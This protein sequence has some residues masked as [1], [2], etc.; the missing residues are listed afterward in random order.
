[1]VR[2][3]T[4]MELM[5]LCIFFLFILTGWGTL[6]QADHGLYAAQKRFFT[7]W[8][9]LAGGFF[10]FPGARFV[11]WVLSL[12]L[13]STAIFRLVYHWRK[14]GLILVH[15]GLMV[16]MMSAFMTFHF[17]QESFLALEEGETA[18][19]SSDYYDWELSLWTQENRNQ[20]NVTAINLT[21]SILKKA[22]LIPKFNVT[23]NFIQLYPN[24][25]PLKNTMDPNLPVPENVSGIKGLQS[26]GKNPD[27]ERNLPGGIVEFISKGKKQRV[28]FF[29]G[30]GKPTQI[31]GPNGLFLAQFRKV[32]KPLPM[33]V[34]LI[35]FVKN[36]HPGTEIASNYEST[37]E[38][39]TG[40]IKRNVRIYMNHP[41]RYKNFTF[42]QSSF[43][44]GPDG[45]EISIFSVVQN[46]GRLLPYYSCGIVFGGLLIHFLIGFFGFL[47]KQANLKTG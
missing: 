12:A 19:V 31:Q 10:P 11:L 23:L 43:S 7:S 13:L 46:K 42:F 3:L 24:A 44:V 26:I 8:Y 17:A 25:A 28:L 2:I 22:F 30:D 15:Y 39:I 37:V 47:K 41:L 14:L 36:E 45:K 38:L 9:F 16:M 27:P 18:N 5:T 1:M 35:D 32:R 20:K 29:G 34:K 4:S 33:T 21:E 6:Y 40:E